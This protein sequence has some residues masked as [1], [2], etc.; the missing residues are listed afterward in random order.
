LDQKI[1]IFLQVI[2]L[3]TIQILTRDKVHAKA[4]IML[5]LANISPIHILVKGTSKNYFFDAVV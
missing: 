4:N 1:I 5:Y 2:S 3:C